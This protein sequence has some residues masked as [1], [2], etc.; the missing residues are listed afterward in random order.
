[1]DHTGN[2]V[3]GQFKAQSLTKTVYDPKVYTDDQIFKLGKQAA[4]KGFSQ[5]VKNGQR[6]YDSSAGGINFHVYLD[7]VQNIVT[8]FFP[9]GK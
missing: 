6:E 2:I 7:K 4:D 5:A 3:P 8:S 9:S 1:M